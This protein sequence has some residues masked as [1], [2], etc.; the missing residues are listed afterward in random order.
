MSADI[1][2][3]RD[4]LYP[5]SNGIEFGSIHIQVYSPD[6][7][8]RVPLII[9]SKSGHSPLKNIDSIVRIMQSDIF[10]R[11]F[12]DIKKNIDIYIK[13]SEEQLSEYGNHSHIK[14]V[15]TDNGIEYEGTDR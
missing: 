10:D 15:F 14:V 12:I 11:V 2:L 5:T 4:M 3:E 9:E 7:Y 1:L 8:A 6:Q 13:V